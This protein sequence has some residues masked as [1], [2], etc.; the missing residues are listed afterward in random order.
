MRHVSAVA[1]KF[2]F[3]LGRAAVRR[4]DRLRAEPVQERMRR[5]AEIDV[6][7]TPQVPPDK[8]RVKTLRDFFA[9]FKAAHANARPDRRDKT[10]RQRVHR[11]I[12]NARHQATPTRVHRRDRATITRC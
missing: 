1:E 9:D 11:F 4:V 2:V 6:R 3:V 8:S 7:T 5:G 10:R 12:H